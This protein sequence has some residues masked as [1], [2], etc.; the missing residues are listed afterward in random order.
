M[1][2]PDGSPPSFRFHAAGHVVWVEIEIETRF[3]L[4]SLSLVRPV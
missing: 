1:L 3:I 4:N 2:I